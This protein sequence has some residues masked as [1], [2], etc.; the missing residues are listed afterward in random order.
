MKS[1]KM[2][3]SITIFIY[4]IIIVGSL[5]IGNMKPALLKTVLAPITG[6]TILLIP[7]NELNRILCEIGYGWNES[8]RLFI[9][10]KASATYSEHMLSAV[11]RWDDN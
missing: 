9:Q 2:F 1:N 6:R 4:T 10:D 5:Y 11:Y 7:T 3:I 8:I